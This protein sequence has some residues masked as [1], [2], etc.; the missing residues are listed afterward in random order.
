[1]MVE[2]FGNIFCNQYFCNFDL[3]WDMR[4]INHTNQLILRLLL[5][6]NAP[7]YVA[8]LCWFPHVM[9]CPQLRTPWISN[10]APRSTWLTPPITGLPLS[11]PR[12]VE[13]YQPPARKLP[14]PL[15]GQ[16][17]PHEMKIFWPVLPTVFQISEK[18]VVC[19]A[20]MR[21]LKSTQFYKGSKSLKQ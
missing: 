13:G 10:Y 4:Y 3:I 7:S 1:M 14:L 12:Y 6:L 15:I 5:M 19:Q 20:I 17:L 9:G 11:A 2:L 16:P 8:W 18:K 21:I